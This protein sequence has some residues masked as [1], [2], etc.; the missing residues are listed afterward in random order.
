MLNQRWNID[1]IR[2]LQR[3]WND[4]NS[5]EMIGE[6]LNRSPESVIGMIAPLRKKGL[7]LVRRKRG[8]KGPL[9]SDIIAMLNGEES[10]RNDADDAAD[11]ANNVDADETSAAVNATEQEQFAIARAH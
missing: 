7:D 5:A 1:Q 10:R 2:I 9:T 4:G 3:M 11:N 8:A 6:E